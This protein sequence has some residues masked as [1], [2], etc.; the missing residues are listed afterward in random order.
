MNKK[1]IIF[2]VIFSAM[3]FFNIVILPERVIYLI[4]FGIT[5]LMI[6]FLI[7]QGIYGKVETIKQSFKY[8][9][10]LILT[11]V[12]LSMV[13]AQAYHSQNIALTLWAQRFMYFYFFYFILH[14]IKPDIK[15]LEKILLSVGAIYTIAYLIQYA[16]YPM[17][18]FNV[19]Q[20]FDRGTIRIFLSGSGFLALALFLS[21]QR[22][23]LKNEI[24]YVFYVL[25]FFGILVLMGTRNFLASMILVIIY[26][27]VF[28]KTI[29]SRYIIYFL[30]LVSVIPVYI[31]F[32]DIFAGMIELSERQSQDF[33]SDI[34]VRSATFFLTDFFPN[35]L[36]HVFGNGQ[37]HG[38]S[39]FGMRVT[40]YSIQYGYYQSDVGVIG[41]YSKFGLIYVIGYFWIFLKIFTAR[42]IPEYRYI[43]FYFLLAVLTLPF[44]STGASS[45]V[46]ASIL[47]YIVDNNNLV[48]SER[49]EMERNTIGPPG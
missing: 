36:A 32:Q 46:A 17:T 37:H 24:K 18:L 7:V 11:G 44:G 25:L 13:I 21:L 9:V 28:S 6:G 12:L 40:S 39:I 26:S 31:I 35:G 1:I 29:R 38:Q 48:I 19:R 8:P 49:K 41:D 34:R 43:K 47:M 2:L 27:L 15:D 33:E 16:L 10:I 5:S 23:Y 42:L 22:F 14:F 3:E 45:I 20:D 4:Q 30:I